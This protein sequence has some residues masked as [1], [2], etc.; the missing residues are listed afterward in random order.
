M[1]RSTYL[2][3]AHFYLPDLKIESVHPLYRTY[4]K[5]KLIYNQ[6]LRFKFEALIVWN[7]KRMAY[8]ILFNNIFKNLLTFE[9]KIFL[10]SSLSPGY[11]QSS[12]QFLRLTCVC[13][14]SY[15]LFPC[16]KKVHLITLT[17]APLILLKWAY[18]ASTSSDRRCHQTWRLLR[19]LPFPS[20]LDYQPSELSGLSEYPLELNW[21][22][23]WNHSIWIQIHHLVWWI[24]I[25][26]I[27]KMLL[28]NRIR[29]RNLLVKSVLNEGMSNQFAISDSFLNS[30]L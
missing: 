14:R 6:Q 27:V 15:S 4:T 16:P 5:L 2:V 13:R 24:I 30:I 22:K 12:V 23:I 17:T 18:M 7:G 29:R 3:S 11:H 9:L 8:P 10:Q 25:A 19:V 21:V 20:W 1:Y 28:C 26:N